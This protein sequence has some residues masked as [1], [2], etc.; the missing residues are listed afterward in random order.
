E[1]ALDLAAVVR[2]LVLQEG[3]EAL[4]AF[5]AV[6]R[7]RI[8]LGIAGA[9]ILRGFLEVLLVDRGVVEGGHGLLVLLHLLGV[10]GKRGGARDQQRKSGGKDWA[11][12]LNLLCRSD[13]TSHA[14]REPQRDD[15]EGDQNYQPNE[16]GH[17]ERQ[18]AGEDRREVMS[19]ITLFMTNTIIPTGGWISP[20]S[21]V[22]TMMTPNQIGSK[23]SSLITGKMIGTVR[24]TMASASIRHP[25]TTYITMI[26]AS[27]P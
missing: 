21:T 27:T 25:S 23:P 24:I 11:N 14:R 17:D 12:H 16:V 2:E 3:D 4:E 8:V 1:D 20:S 5:P 10:G 26:S 7:Q 15:R 19:W 9:Q 18:D 6:G 22:I 13:A